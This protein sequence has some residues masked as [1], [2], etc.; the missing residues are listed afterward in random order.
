MRKSVQDKLAKYKEPRWLVQVESLPKTA[1]V[2]CR[3]S[4]SESPLGPLSQEVTDFLP[5]SLSSSRDDFPPSPQQS[6]ARPFLCALSPRREP[7]FV[8]QKPG[9][10][11]GA[12][13]SSGMEIRV[14]I[15]DVL[16]RASA[17]GDRHPGL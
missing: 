14:W 15:I 13:F 4:S 5:Y 6:I 1:P 11:R 8:C 3:G 9:V 17:E 10:G 12:Y 7:I 16:R 2:S